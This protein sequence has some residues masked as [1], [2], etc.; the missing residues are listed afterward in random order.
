MDSDTREGE[1]TMIRAM[2]GTDIEEIIKVWNRAMPHHAIDNRG[3]V[4]NILLDIFLLLLIPI[5]QIQMN[6]K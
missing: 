1:M 2:K 5:A 3:F 4:K 6:Y